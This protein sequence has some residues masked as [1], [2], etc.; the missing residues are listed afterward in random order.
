MYE[1]KRLPPGSVDRALEKAD[2]YREL[3]QPEEAESICRDVLDISPGNPTALKLLGLAL[4]DRFP[5]A[6]TSVFDE[7]L[8]VF[9]QLESEYE[10]LYY[11]GIAYER[12]AKAQLEDGQAHNAVV[13]FETAL[14][15]F[16][17]CEPLAPKGHPEPVLRWNR[18]V[19]ILTEHPE[20]VAAQ[21]RARGS[22]HSVLGD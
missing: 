2:H 6:W 21:G 17:K 5:S 9:N 18:C 16:E 3:N 22:L 14:D 19:R 12:C 10:R 4:T 13:S 20:L 1:L 7:A 15:Y 8:R 11:A